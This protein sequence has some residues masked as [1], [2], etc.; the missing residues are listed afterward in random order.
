[1]NREELV[2]DSV[3]IR[4]QYWSSYNEHTAIELPFNKCLTHY[5][6]HLAVML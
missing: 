1:M 2:V 4:L 5:V 6:L 3:V